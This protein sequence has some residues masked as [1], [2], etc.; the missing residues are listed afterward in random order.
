MSAMADIAMVFRWGPE[1]M[2]AMDLAELAEWREHARKRWELMHG[3]GS[4][5]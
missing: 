2:A 1:Q 5:T 3:T 4:S